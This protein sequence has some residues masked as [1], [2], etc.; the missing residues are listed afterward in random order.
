MRN[1]CSFCV[2]FACALA[3][4]SCVTAQEP[5]VSGQAGVTV[6]GDHGY[7]SAGISVGDARLLAAQHSLSGGKPLPPGIAKNLA[8]GKPLPPGIAK[9]RLPQAFVAQLPQHPGYQW[10]QAGTDL[11]LVVSGSFV[12]QDVLEGVFK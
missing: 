2:L 11:V 6:A 12:V 1:I 5:R 10:Q 7:I 4:S 9:N 8:R 3:A